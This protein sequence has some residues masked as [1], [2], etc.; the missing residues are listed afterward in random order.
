MKK[1]FRSILAGA[2][3][4]L[5]VSCYDDSGIRKDIADLD[6]RV[7]S[8]EETLNSEVGGIADLMA[9]LETLEGKVAAIKVETKDGIT[10]LTLSNGS[11]VV[12]SKDGVLT[13]KDGNWATIAADGT[14]SVLP[15]KVSHELDFIVEDGYLKVSYDGNTYE[16]TGVMVSEYTAHVIGDVVTAEDRKSVTVTIGD[17]TFELPLMSSGAA[18][19]ASR[20]N[21]YVGYGLTKTFTVAGG[22]FY[23]DSKPDGWKVTIEGN[24]VSVVAP[25]KEAAESGFFE[26]E[27]VIM[28]HPIGV[29]APVEVKV[30]CGEAFS[31]TVDNATGNVTIFNAMTAEIPDQTGLGE[32]TFDF[33]D[34][35]IGILP[36]SDYEYFTSVD[37]LIEAGEYYSIPAGMLMSIKD[38]EGLGGNYVSGEYEEDCFT[39]SISDL[40]AAFYPRVS[41]EE[42]VH[43]VVWAVPQTDH[44]LKDMLV[45]A[46]YK[47]VVITLTEKEVSFNE[48]TVD[49]KCSGATSYYA[50]VY[51][52]E[53]FEQMTFEQFMELGYIGQGPWK[54][55]QV[56]GDPRSMGTVVQAGELKLSYLQY[57]KPLSPN[58]EYLVCVFPFDESKDPESYDMETDLLP[59]L[60][61]FTTTAL[62][63]GGTP[64][65]MSLNVATTSY[66]SIAVDVNVPEAA[67]VYYRFVDVGYFDD[68]ESDE[69]I[70]EYIMEYCYDPLTEN[71][72]VTTSASAGSRKQLVLVALT[73]DGKY[74]VSK[75]VYSALSYPYNSNIAV[76]LASTTFDSETGEYT[77]VLNV[78][79]ATKVAVYNYY[80]TTSAVVPNNVLTHGLTGSYS[81]YK[82]ADVVD[83]KATIV[84]KPSSSSYKYLLVSAYNVSETAVTDLSEVVSFDLTASVAQ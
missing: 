13:T 80:T 60:Y 71:K 24:V 6:D 8:I 31:V 67:T 52:K 29:C 51:E 46:Y 27:G 15:Y 12:L 45:E 82:W 43:Y 21:M 65:T 62:V 38:T 16:S 36:V 64:A 1:T 14:I 54:E 33:A 66:T 61:E 63:S 48:I 81:S 73:S 2:I 47:P 4:L 56:S 83:G 7:A 50:A 42:G 70:A 41:I 72:T 76:T 49:L 5:A 34:A 84:V 32:S 25:S 22:D 58:T 57:D 78:T 9:R 17:Q 23:V 18:I 28:L 77:V 55:F 40:G 53:M 20:T 3:A 59:Y 30:S 10:T 19:E 35:L 26:T 69:Q 11:S 44:F 37:E 74:A 68:Y 75:E 79:G 39:L